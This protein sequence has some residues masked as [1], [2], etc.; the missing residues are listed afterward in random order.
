MSLPKQLSLQTSISTL[1]HTI[2][3]H[4]C[5]I[6]IVISMQI[7]SPNSILDHQSV[8]DAHA[9]TYMRVCMCVCI[10]VLD[11]WLRITINVASGSALPLLSERNNWIPR[12]EIDQQNL[13]YFS[14][15]STSY[16]EIY[17]EPWRESNYYSRFHSSQNI[18]SHNLNTCKISHNQFDSTQNILF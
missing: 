4:T 17:I 15:I 9:F 5:S 16:T 3:N 1:L 6:I 11:L 18:I 12:L 8:H 7:L 10:C 14:L 2:V 13:G